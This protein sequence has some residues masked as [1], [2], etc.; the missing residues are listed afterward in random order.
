MFRCFHSKKKKRPN[1]SETCRPEVTVIWMET[2]EAVG[3]PGVD[4]GLPEDDPD[5]DPSL[6][7]TLAEFLRS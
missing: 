2:L 4:V 7:E 1:R 3:L 5:R 6:Q